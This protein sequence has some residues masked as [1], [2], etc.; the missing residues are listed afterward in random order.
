MF[1]KRVITERLILFP[2]TY[3]IVCSVLNGETKELE[4]LGYKTDGKWPRSDT[5]DILPII[6]DSLKGLKQ[7][8][9]FELW[10][11]VKK[12]DMVIIGD[13]GF[14]GEPN[15]K[16]EIE[17]GYGLIEDERKKG[18]GYESV[19]ELIKWGFS[20]EN[21]KKIK[22]ECLINNIGSIKILQKVGLTEIKRDKE[23]IYWECVN[24]KF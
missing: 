2:L 23:M 15:E 19:K 24:P 8:T 21:V 13:L 5:L 22:A 10:I 14:K 6:K 16:G 12:E 3:D 7:S 4:G 20:Q 11:I 17:I 9:G 1:D 18:Y